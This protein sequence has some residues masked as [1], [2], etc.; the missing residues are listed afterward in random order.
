MTV[1]DLRSKII[2][3]P[4]M[5]KQLMYYGSELRG[6]RSFWSKKTRELLDMINECGTPH[7]FFTL[8]AADLWND[9]LQ[10]LAKGGDVKGDHS[11]R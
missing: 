7:L 11:K 6:T 8:S 1:A 4:E 3:Q 2:M 9:C 10:S 5:T